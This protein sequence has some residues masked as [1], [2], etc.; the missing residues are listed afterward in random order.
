MDKFFWNNRY[1]EKKTG[2]DI[3]HPSTPIKEYIDQLRD[4][5]TQILIPGCGN[6]YEAEYLFQRYKNVFLLD[7]AP[8]ALHRFANRV[9]QF[10]KKTSLKAIFFN[11]S[12][13]DLILEQTFLSIDPSLRNDYVRYV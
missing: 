13:Y 2:W 10:P 11:T 12:N 4:K 3:G 1:H 7:I 9:Q 5:D 6:A 8:L